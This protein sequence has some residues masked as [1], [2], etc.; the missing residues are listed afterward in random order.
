MTD[1]ESILDRA[2]FDAALTP[3]RPRL[4][5]ALR[6]RVAGAA[7]AEDVAQQTLLRAWEKRHSFDDTRP[8]GPWLLSIAF[9]QA[10][11]HR[12]ARGRRT[13]HEASAGHD[14]GRAARWSSAEPDPADIGAA[15]DR[16]DAV[17]SAVDATL[18][19]DAWAVVWL[20]YREGH[21]VKDAAK[22]IGRSAGATRVLLHR[23][24]AKLADPLSAID[25]GQP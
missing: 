16:R 2:R 11:D 12:R 18:D 23:A 14:V 8:L 25:G 19:G 10:A 9:R 4:V 3:W 17:W 15:A 13:H 5:A 7:D 6:G 20:V 21:S 22:V 1:G 24:R